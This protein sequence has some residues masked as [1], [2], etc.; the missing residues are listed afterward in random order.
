MIGSL[1]ATTAAAPASGLV[2][3]ATTVAPLLLLRRRARRATAA[4]GRGRRGVGE[5][6]DAAGPPR[7]ASHPV[8]RGGYR[9]MWEAPPRGR[10]AALQAAYMYRPIPQA[11]DSPS[12]SSHSGSK[13]QYYSVPHVIHVTQ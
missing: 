8:R 5:R 13:L 4:A 12:Q 11:A 2:P 3:P 7:L 6:L 10:C 1:S 9:I